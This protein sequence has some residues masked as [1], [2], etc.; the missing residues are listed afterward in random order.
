MSDDGTPSRGLAPLGD[1]HARIL[2]LGSLP[3]RESLR[4][5]Q[6]YAHPRNAFWPIMAELFDVRGDYAARCLGLR[7]ARVAVWDVL[8]SSVRP[9]SL[10][11]SIDLDS[12]RANDFTRFLA[13]RRR[14]ELVAFNGQKA[15]ALFRRFCHVEG[16]ELRFVTLPSTSPAYAAMSY[17][18]KL[19]IWRRVL[20]ATTGECNDE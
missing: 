15:A 7:A 11:A 1:A 2:V 8:E 20:C 12:A 17:A 3:G 13:S 4:R 6:Y 19:Q 5:Q 10:D 9:G 16:D 18:D 14:L